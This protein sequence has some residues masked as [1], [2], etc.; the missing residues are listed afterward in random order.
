MAR[1]SWRRGSG[2]GGAQLAGSGRRRGRWVRRTS[3]RRGQIDVGQFGAGVRRPAR[4]PPRTC[5]SSAGPTPSARRARHRVDGGQLGGD[6]PAS[7]TTE[8]AAAAETGE[9]PRGAALREADQVADER[10]Q[11]V[12]AAAGRGTAADDARPA[13]HR[14]RRARL[15]AVAASCPLDRHPLRLALLRLRELRRDDDQTEVDHEERADLTTDPAN[16][17]TVG[18]EGRN[19]RRPRTVLA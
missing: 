13:R 2:G 14:A 17:S 5:R 18:E 3:R 6:R 9:E 1:I 10:E 19:M 15:P 16:V 7:A 8:A 12:V 11:F 4:P